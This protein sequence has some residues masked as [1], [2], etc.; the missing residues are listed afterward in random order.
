MDKERLLKLA[1]LLTEQHQDTTGLERLTPGYYWF[2][3]L[4]RE[5]DDEE[6]AIVRYDGADDFEWCGSDE[7]FRIFPGTE[8]Q[9]LAAHPT[10][11]RNSHL[12]KFIGP[13]KPPVGK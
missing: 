7:G 4:V 2:R 3:D 8:E 5:N 9:Y 13:L 6:W 12:G 10:E 11:R 1:G